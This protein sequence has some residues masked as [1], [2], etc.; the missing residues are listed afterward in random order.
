MMQSLESCKAEHA[1]R[2]KVMH[3]TYAECVVD[4]LGASRSLLRRNV[5][6]AQVRR[7]A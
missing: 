5:P 4:R 6:A 7:A 1:A 3:A 2:S